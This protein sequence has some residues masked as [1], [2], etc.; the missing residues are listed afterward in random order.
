[1]RLRN[2][3]SRMLKKHLKYLIDWKPE[4]EGMKGT[5]IKRKFM[6]SFLS[7]FYPSKRK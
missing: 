7:Y 3:D 4:L 1:M 2:C 6:Q 5:S